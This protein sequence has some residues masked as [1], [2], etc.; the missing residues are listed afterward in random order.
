MW[1][2]LMADLGSRPFLLKASS[3]DEFWQGKVLGSRLNWYN[4]ETSQYS[5]G[6]QIEVCFYFTEVCFY[7]M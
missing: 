4:K 5:I 6:K 7:F 3:K 1:P 2:I